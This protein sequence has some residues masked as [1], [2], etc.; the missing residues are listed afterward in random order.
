MTDP[1][2]ITATTDT[3]HEPRDPAATSRPTERADVVLWV[4][5][6]LGVA[7]NVATSATGQSLL[8]VPFGVAVIV[9]AVALVKRHLGRRK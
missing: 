7:G 2:R 4:V 9:S 6:A 8:G 5:L 3:S 1:Y